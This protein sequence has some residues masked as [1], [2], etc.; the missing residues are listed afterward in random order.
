MNLKLVAAIIVMVVVVAVVAPLAYLMTLKPATPSG[1]PG[2]TVKPQN[3]PPVARMASNATRVLHGQ[4]IRFNGNGSH[5]PDGDPLTYSW[6]FGD[7]GTGTGL[8]AIHQFL[9]DGTFTVGLTVSDGSLANSSFMYVYVFNGAP[10]IRSFLPVSAQVVI[11][12]GQSAQFSIS[13]TDPN[14]DPLAY[15]W[16][17]DGRPQ[18]ISAPAFNYTSSST[19]SGEHR[20]A[21]SVSDG[22]TNATHEWPMTVRNVNTP[23]VISAFSPAASSSVSEGDSLT[24]QATASDPDGDD[25][26][27][28]WVMDGIVKTNGTGLTAGFLYEPDYR[29]NGTHLARVTFS[30]GPS[31]VSLNWTV[32]VKNTNRPPTITNQT[33]P[34]RCSVPEGETQQFVV[35]AGDPDGDDLQF[36]WALDGKPQPDSITSVFTFFTNFTSNGTYHLSVEVSDGSLKTGANWTVTVT[37]VNRAPTAKARVDR[38][39]AFIGDLF[40][41][42]GSASFDP[43]GDPLAYSWDLG[44]GSAGDALEVTHR[45]T[46]E[47]VYKINLT[48]T[49]DGGLSGRASVDVTVNRGIQQVWK[50]QALAE[51]PTQLLVDDIDADGTKEYL[52]ASDGGEDSNGVSH[53]NLSVYDLYT[54]TLEWKSG[55]I[56]SPSNAVATNLDGDPQLELVVGV[57]TSRAG[58]VLSSQWTGRVLVIDGK[59]HSV[60]WQ[61]AALGAINSVAVADVDND[62]QKEIIIGYMH[63][64]SVDMGT[65]LMQED[66]GLAIYNSAFQLMWES[67]GWGATVIMAAELLDLDQLPELVV[68]SVRAVN[69]AGGMGNDTNIT[70]YK[71]LLGDLIKIGAFSAINN[72]YPSAFD[73]ADVNGDM[74]RDIIF[75]DSGGDSDKYSGYLYV[76]SSTMNPIWKS[77]DIGAVMSIKAANVNP[78]SPLTEI[79][80]GIASSMDVNDDL[81]GSMIMFSS[82]WGVIYRTEDIG[83][84][85]SLAAGDLNADGKMEVLMGVRTH[86]D[87]GGNVVSEMLVYSGQVKKELANATGLAEL[88][89]GFVL[90]DTDADSTPEVLFADWKEA[91]TA[92]T[93]YLYEM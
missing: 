30:D 4:E 82:G 76:F 11:F 80:V 64:A 74:T 91:D 85:D 14:N 19:S 15:S 50:A 29:A 22:F 61:G 10:V 89:T 93:V 43:D 88:S 9:T 63:D 13:A 57:T 75:G 34:T 58:T 20:V 53:G 31:S 33:P 87:G 66:G 24:L 5:D 84:V 79:M 1:E 52:V 67:S 7:G 32:L 86:D 56:G 35:V 27:Y 21:A 68:F 78:D 72:L 54:H 77:T 46:K 3:L 17:F 12:E 70:T 71:W 2:H 49:D 42:N 36:A 8:E 59:T 28:V 60:D 81:H 18:P 39:A 23:P 45:Y 92:A 73:L 47:G 38:A 41:F 37:N 55:D 44:D 62:G 26:T 69:I 65:G 16:T 51:R 48:V 40:T 90:V 83:S 6:D 25:L